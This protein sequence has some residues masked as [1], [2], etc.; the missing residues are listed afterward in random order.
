MK[1]RKQTSVVACFYEASILY[2]LFVL[3][4]SNEKP[5]DCSPLCVYYLKYKDKVLKSF[6]Y[7][8]SCFLLLLLLLLFFL[9]LSFF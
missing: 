9:S 4:R 6:A 2:C 5:G 1:A 7:R 8:A 3:T